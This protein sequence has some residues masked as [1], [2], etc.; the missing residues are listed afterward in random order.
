MSVASATKI[1]EISRAQADG[2]TAKQA[3]LD[4][5][6]DISSVEIF[7]DLVLVATFIRS[8]RRASGLLL[9]KENLQEDEYQ[10]KACLVLKAGPHAYTEYADGTTD[11]GRNATVHS[12]VVVAIKDS[13]PLQINGVACRVVPYD[14]IRMRVSNPTM[15]L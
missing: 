2:K 1:E 7:T 15:V 6:G 13:W 12:W 4:A 11:G 8:E 3:L 10:G 14:K 5:I 9:P